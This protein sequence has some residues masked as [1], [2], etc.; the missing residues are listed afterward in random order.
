VLEEAKTTPV[1]AAGGIATGADIRA[2][3]SAG[4]SGAVLGTR[5]FG[6]PRE[7]RSSSLQRR[8]ASS[9]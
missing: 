6:D 9:Q 7:F 2:V 4:A 8:A 3:L 5:F 1:L